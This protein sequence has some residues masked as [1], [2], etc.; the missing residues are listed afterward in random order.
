MSRTQP[1]AASAQPTLLQFD[2]PYTGPWGAAMSAAMAELAQDIAG[3]DGLL[4]KIWT[5]NEATGRAG[6]I[7]LF[8]DAAS[9]ERYR[10]KHAARLQG[11]GV[12][13]IV[14]H[15]FAVNQPLTQTTRG[16]LAPR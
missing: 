10:D 6:G 13:D 1:A 5:E 15:S 12:R 11:F 2:F 9:A 3:E 16:P 8:A 4:W 14:A 7:Y